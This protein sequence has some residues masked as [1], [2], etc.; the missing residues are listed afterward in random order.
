[1]NPAAAKGE[2]QANPIAPLRLKQWVQDLEQPTRTL[3]PV[4]GAPQVLP[5]PP[6]PR[7]P[8]LLGGA[9]GLPLVQERHWGA[10]DIYRHAQGWL[11]PYVKSRVL[12]GSF[13]PI[14]A[15]L[16]TDWKCN[17]DCHYCPSWDNRVPGMT[18]DMAKRSIDWLSSTTCRVLA[19]MGGEPLVRWRLVNKAVD[20]ATSKG[21]WVYL[22]TNGYLLTP[23]IID[24][25]A[26]AGVSV[27]NY[28]VDVV[29]PK[30]GLPKSLNPVRKTFEY[31]LK[32]QYQ[33]G[34]M[35]FFNICICRTNMDDV[36]ELTEIAREY[37]IS[38]DYHIC[39][40][41]M[42]EHAHFKHLDDNPTFL[43]PEDW[44]R[45]DEVVDWLVEKNRAGYSMVN[46]VP[47]LLDM[48]DFVRGKVEPWNCRAGQNALIIRTD[49]TIGP[50]FTLYSAGHDWGYV[51]KPA[52]DPTQL[53]EMKME[54]QRNCFST[55]Q[56][57]LG[58]CYNDRRVIRWVGGRLLHRSR[59]Q[60]RSFE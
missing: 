34:Y 46:S 30:P 29:N 32:K 14:I 36:R 55:L 10:H 7:H 52:F 27:F 38:T 25:L 26:D 1:M 33:Y 4:A 20:Y 59:G 53:Q 3:P 11:F 9:D 6:F 5:D 24:R 17:I 2:S 18:E 56:H 22:G 42:Y 49:G 40:A 41:P 13:H 8:K 21:F 28:A 58:F 48:K 44:P 19:F 16:F 54:C 47:R 35:V 31:L 15:Y 43:T 37:R 45:V 50:C 39:E 57:N 23:D 12:P 51:G 60:A